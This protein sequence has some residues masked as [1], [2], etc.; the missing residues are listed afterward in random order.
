M[1]VLF[2]TVI[3]FVSSYLWLNLNHSS[4]PFWETIENKFSSKDETKEVK[5]VHMVRQDG[6]SQKLTIDAYLEGVIGSEMSASFEME[7]LKAQCVASRTFV[8]QRKYEVDDTTRTQVYHDE[9]QLKQ[10]WGKDY[11]MYHERIRSAIKETKNEIMTY[12]GKPITAAFFSS[13]C[14]KTANSEEYWQ[15]DTP[16]LKSV[17]S[18]WDQKDDSYRQT[19]VFSED[20]FHTLLGFTN[21]VSEISTPQLYDSGY[22]KSIKID[23]IV[24]SGREIREKLNLRSSSFVITKQKDG[25]HVTTLGYGHGIGMSQIGA[26]QMALEKKTYK[27]ILNHYYTDIEIVDLDV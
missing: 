26:Q 8:V 1:K 20:E 12:K 24:F 23:Q 3:L 14:G 13:S 18:L 6:T 11:K 21:F 10:I 19:V 5:M 15:K 4:T 27:E 2:V 17:D 22:V 9:K 16:Y 25:Y 7:A